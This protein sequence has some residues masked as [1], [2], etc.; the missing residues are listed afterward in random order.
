M[1]RL[2][3]V[4]PLFSFSLLF[5]VQAVVAS[6][7]PVSQSVS[8]GVGLIA[9]PSARMNPEGVFGVHLSLVDP[10]TRAVV[11]AQPLPWLEVLFKYTNVENQIYGVSNQGYKDKSTDVKIRLL[12]E[13]FY[14]PSISVGVR[15]V[16]GTGL[17]SGE[18]VVA[19]KQINRFDFSLGLGWGYLGN[20]EH[21]SNPLCTL[22][23]NFCNRGSVTGKGGN[24]GLANLFSGKKMAL[25]GGVEYHQEALPISWKLEY[26][27]NSYQ[28]EPFGSQ[29]EQKTPLNFGAVYHFSDSIKLQAGL[30]RGTTAM[31]GITFETNLK[32]STQVKYFDPAPVKVD[33]VD[34]A[35]EVQWQSIEEAIE[36][37]AGFQVDS[38][39]KNDNEIIV[40]GRQQVYA[41][42]AKGI[43]RASRILEN[44]LPSEFSKFT[45]VDSYQGIDVSSITIDREE[46]RKSAR[47]E[48]PKS[49][50]LESTE[51]A[52]NKA[53]QELEPVWEQDPGKL[54][55]RIAPSFS[56]SYGGPDEFLL[57]QLS[58]KS[59]AN[60][61]L[62]NN[63]WLTG[64]ISLGLVD[65]YENFE[66]TAPSNLPRVRTDIKEYLKTSRLRLNTLQLINLESAGDDFFYT[67]YLGYLEMMYGGV[68]GE[69][70][71]RPY[72]KKWALGLD[73]NYVKQRDFDLRLG[74]RDYEVLTG[75]L[76]GYYETDDRVVV[77]LSA[78]R[79]LAKDIGMTFGVK[80]KFKNNASMGFWVTKTN[81]SAEE[82]GEGSFDKGFYFSIPL[83]IFTLSSTNYV[84]DY[85]WQFLTRDGGQK[86]NRSQ[87]LYDLT[88]TRR[89]NHIKSGF[90]N[91]L[92]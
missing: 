44:K 16:G 70:L 77:K 1:N 29:F 4:Y 67:T 54:N 62:K 43:G 21:L 83:D 63:T 15:D 18:Y 84:A 6:P 35:K 55:Y 2:R 9:M 31:L 80:R 13:S 30:V 12:A 17:F 92:D 22:R 41:Q 36:L 81:V 51:F 79:Y 65:N 60:Y 39:Y 52:P 49:K 10:Y 59:S 14:V 89:L 66:Y 69:V 58:M 86:L 91:V 74:F 82:F 85:S 32:S 53:V 76:T 38:I 48:Q 68:G 24:L 47:L 5:F 73:L 78:G 88:H 40:K 11:F 56:G 33:V 7:L 50:V 27:G 37:K 26:D 71:Y 72:G 20:Q 34:K 87:E 3:F 23:E 28:N 57:Y 8:G 19:S 64:A 75:H 45:F 25:F 61:S 90:D 46:F 42:E